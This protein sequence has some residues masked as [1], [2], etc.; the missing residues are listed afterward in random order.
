M[1]GK[2]NGGSLNKCYSTGSVSGT[3]RV[4]GIVGLNSNGVMNNNYSTGSVNG[5]DCIGGLLG[6]NY[7]GGLNNNYSTGSVNGTSGVGG[8]VG[9]GDPIQED[10]DGFWDTITSGQTSSYGGIGKTTSEMKTQSTFTNAGWNFETIWEMIG[11]NYPRLREIPDPTLPVELSNFTA[12]YLNNTPTLYWITQSETDNMG[13]FV[14]RNIEEDFTTSEK[15]SEFLEGHGTTTQQQSYIYEDTIEN[16]EIGD[17]YYYW[18]ESIDFSGMVNH[19]DKVAVLTIPEQYDPGSGLIPEPV[20]YGLFQNE[21]NPLLTSTRIA[22]NLTETA[23]VDLN[24]YNL[25]GQRVKTLYSGVTS[26]HTIM[27]D[28]KDESG[29]ELENGVYFYKLMVNGKTEET[30]KLILMRQATKLH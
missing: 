24:I 3:D 15:V 23:M 2:L 9:M 1:G 29:K 27:W 30:K 8:L 6:Y 19:Y 28:G 7:W 20:R 17:T 21:P 14:Y 18:L 22:F 12:Q 5:N 26:K 10:G 13:W 4:G 25:K 11:Y 16:P